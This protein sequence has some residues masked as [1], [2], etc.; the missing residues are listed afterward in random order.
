MPSSFGISVCT[1]KVLGR[2]LDSR[3]HLRAVTEIASRTMFAAVLRL[4]TLIDC[5]AGT[6][7]DP[8]HYPSSRCVLPEAAEAAEATGNTEQ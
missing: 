1:R 4:T 3:G 7:A 6:V 5:P 2:F 8:S